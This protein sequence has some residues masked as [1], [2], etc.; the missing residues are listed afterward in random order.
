MWYRYAQD[1]IW[2]GIIWSGPLGDL[3]QKHID[4]RLIKKLRLDSNPNVW[5]IIVDDDETYEIINQSILEDS[6]V[7]RERGSFTGFGHFSQ[8]RKN[9]L[10]A[11]G[12][13]IGCG[14]LSEQHGIVIIKKQEFDSAILI[15]E[16]T[17]ASRHSRTNPFSSYAISK[18]EVEANINEG[19]AERI[20]YENGQTLSKYREDD[21]AI[22]YVK[23]ITGQLN[24]AASLRRMFI[25]YL[26]LYSNNI[27][28]DPKDL[29]RLAMKIKIFLSSLSLN[30]SGHSPNSQLSKVIFA[31]MH[32]SLDPDT[33][34][35][36]YENIIHHRFFQILED[37][38]I[39][40]EKLNF[41]SEGRKTEVFEMFRDLIDDASDAL[42]HQDYELAQK[43]LTAID[44]LYSNLITNADKLLENERPYLFNSMDKMNTELE[45]T[46]GFQTP[47]TNIKYPQNPAEQYANLPE[48]DSPEYTTA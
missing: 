14:N 42:Y 30:Y 41:I 11:V 6:D 7:K 35:N 36:N 3:L 20:A 47:S 15:H 13:L 21:N 23:F 27:T 25:R 9:N 19:L 18:E 38:K 17:H 10:S 39:K 40:I 12:E 46:V 31:M 28:L 8:N 45:N 4:S 34:L 22:T 16:A 1:N 43:I 32:G 26:T 24:D 5:A 2:D 37:D 33:L 29:N 44:A 48:V